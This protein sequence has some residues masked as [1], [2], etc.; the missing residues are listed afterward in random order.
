[1]PLLVVI[2]GPPC[3]G[4]T[5]IA[6]RLSEALSL[7]LIGKDDVKE[8]LFDSLGWSDRDWSRK[9]SGV[10]YEVIYLFLD[11]LLAAGISCIV[12][13]N[14]RPAVDAPRIRSLIA[15]RAADHL[16]IVCRADG[17]VLVQR[18]CDRWKCGHR[19]P[20]HV[21]AESLAELEPGLLA[22]GDPTLD[23]GGEVVELDTTDFEQVDT[24]ALIAAARDALQKAEGGADA[25][26]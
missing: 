15:D 21:D 18:F 2:T 12:E 8:V 14:F 26:H 13:S 6:R 10:G 24:D 4:K 19:H 1:M 20:G 11:R 16:Q 3:S 5:A 17:R 9:L 22:G 25:R 23:L 7:P